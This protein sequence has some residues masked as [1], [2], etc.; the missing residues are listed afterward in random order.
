MRTIFDAVK[1]SRDYHS[2]AHCRA[3]R[4]AIRS[5]APLQNQIVTDHQSQ[6]W[7]TYH[8]EDRVYQVTIDDGEGG[9]GGGGGI[10]HPN[11]SQGGTAPQTLKGQSPPTF[12]KYI[13]L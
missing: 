9:D 7:D 1:E 11:I 6:I 5:N 2:A 3:E 10:K 4:A 8:H 13:I 12:T